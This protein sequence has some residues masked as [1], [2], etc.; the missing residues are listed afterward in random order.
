MNLLIEWVAA[1][2]YSITNFFG[3]LND[4]SLRLLGAYNGCDTEESW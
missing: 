2:Y 1:I 3:E 4:T